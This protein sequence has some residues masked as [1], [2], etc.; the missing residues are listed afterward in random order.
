MSDDTAVRRIVLALG[1]NLGDSLELLQG[2]VDALADTP[3]LR[4][5]AVSP[6]YE[7]DPVGGPDQPEYLNAVVVAEGRHS[8]R[9]LLER[10]LAVENAFDRVREVRWG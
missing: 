1:S 5:V 9:T 2:A 3:G 4:L 10:A 7:T 6:V 8:P